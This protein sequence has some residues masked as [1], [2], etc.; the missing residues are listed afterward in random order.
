LAST[1]RVRI[2]AP[3]DPTLFDEYDVAHYQVGEI[4]DF[5]VRLATLL[6]LMG[7]AEEISGSGPTSS[8]WGQPPRSK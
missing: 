1:V 4:F 8:G 7:C 2:T 6:I 3:P 5:P